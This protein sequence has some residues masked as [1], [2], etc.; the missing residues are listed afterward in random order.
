M[1]SVLRRWLSSNNSCDFVYKRNSLN[2]T[3]L[4]CLE[5]NEI[6][7]YFS[8]ETVGCSVSWPLSYVKSSICSVNQCFLGI[9]LNQV[10]DPES[11]RN[12]FINSSLYNKRSYA[13]TTNVSGD[14]VLE[15]FP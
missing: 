7:F 15:L 8:L 3:F 4:K 10:R 13:K 14:A 2:F 6:R 9:S 12:K 11:T 1:G 5:Q